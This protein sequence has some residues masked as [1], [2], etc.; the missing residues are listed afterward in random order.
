MRKLRSLVRG[1]I[2]IIVIR[3]ADKSRQIVICDYGDYRRAAVCL[4]H[5]HNKY[6]KIPHNGNMR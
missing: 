1:K 5:N 2:I 6:L 3:K 4:L